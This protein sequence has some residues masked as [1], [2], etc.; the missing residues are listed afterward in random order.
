MSSPVTQ[1]SPRAPTFSLGSPNVQQNTLSSPTTASFEYDFSN[2][3]QGAHI[4]NHW[5]GM[6]SGGDANM[7]MYTGDNVNSP[8]TT[9]FSMD[10]QYS[11]NFASSQLESLYPGFNGFSSTTEGFPAPGLPFRGL[12][13]IKNYNTEATN[14]YPMADQDLWQQGYDPMS[15]EYGPDVPFSL[16]DSTTDEQAQASQSHGHSHG[17]TN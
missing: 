13:F 11:G 5:N 6:D 7:N 3:N 15:F 4:N 14:N 8:Y 2:L 16:G 1:T 10:D 17:H 12:D 9:N